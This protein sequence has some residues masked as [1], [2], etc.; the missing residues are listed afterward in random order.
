MRERVAVYGGKLVAE[1]TGS[2]FHVLA[3]IPTEEAAS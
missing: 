1:P 2:G 3:R